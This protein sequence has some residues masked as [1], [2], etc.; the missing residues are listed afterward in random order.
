MKLNTLTTLILLSISTGAVAEDLVTFKQGDYITASDMNNN[1]Q[2]LLD[3][4]SNPQSLSSA[5]FYDVDC[6]EDETQLAQFTSASHNSDFV[7]IQIEGD[8][9]WDNAEATRGQM[10]FT[11]HPDSSETASIQSSG[12]LHIDRP[13]VGFTNLIVP[14]GFH[15]DGGGS[16]W[17]E[18]ITV[19]EGAV[20]LVDG[21]A[22]LAF[23]NIQAD[24]NLEVINGSRVWLNQDAIFNNLIV[25]SSQFA[26][27]SSIQANY[28]EVKNNGY[29][30]IPNLTAF[31]EVILRRGGVLSGDSLDTTWLEMRENSAV[32]LLNLSVSDG[33]A[34]R[35]GAILKVDDT[36]DVTNNFFVDSGS[37][38]QASTVTSGDMIQ[39]FNGS[40]FKVDS[41]SALTIE[42]QINSV[43]SGG[44]LTADNINVSRSASIDAS[45]LSV[46]NNIYAA[47]RSTITASTVSTGT[48]GLFSSDMAVY[49]QLN[50][51]NFDADHELKWSLGA[52]STLRS[53]SVDANSM[54]ADVFNYLCA[55]A[56]QGTTE[57][58]YGEVNGNYLWF[59]GNCNDF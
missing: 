2:V 4:V 13:N 6:S 22:T 18:N 51:A 27:N 49:D 3:K 19:N 12:S 57:F 9:L 37:K 10:L 38:V 32:N 29:S 30:W 28:V 44:S 41:A 14:N 55:N 25:S 47:E 58:R 56:D 31:S 20:Y 16:G 5:A 7:V 52:Y 1:F 54:S 17:I 11:T 40:I 35:L 8:C 15:Y 24:A 23:N 59:P 26:T 21:N 33:I 48:I 39:A 53:P 43:I 42:A 36:I 45:N 50:I 34:M 46:T